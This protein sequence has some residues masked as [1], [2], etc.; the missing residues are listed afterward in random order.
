MEDEPNNERRNMK[1]QFCGTERGVSRYIGGPIH[2]MCGDCKEKIE[3]YEEVQNDYLKFKVN[4][5]GVPIP[6]TEEDSL[7][8]ASVKW[9]MVEAQQKISDAFAQIP[10]MEDIETIKETG[11]ND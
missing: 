6:E 3:K 5:A 10:F 8:K 7:L 11:G 2:S 4:L 9:K 1:C